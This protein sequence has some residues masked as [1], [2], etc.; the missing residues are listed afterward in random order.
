LDTLTSGRP[1]FRSLMW[2]I[3][4][5]LVIGALAL[6]AG[7]GGDEESAGGGASLTTAVSTGGGDATL[8]V[9]GPEGTK[10]YSLDDLEG[11]PV[12]EGYWG[13]KSSTGRIT[14]PVLAKGVSL[15]DLFKEVGGLPD[16]MAVGITAKDGYEMTMSVTQLKSGDFITYDMVTGDEKKVDGPLTVIVAYEYD[17]KPLDP[18]TDGPLR[19]AMVS[20]EKNQVT[21]GHWSIKWTN[22][23]E[24]KA[25]EQEWTLMLKGKLTE[26]IDKATFESGAAE[27]CHGQSWTDADGNTW[28]G[29]PLYLLVGRVDDDVAHEGPAY[30]REL[31]QA[32]YQVKIT[33]ADG[34]SIEVASTTMYYKKDIIVAYRLNGAALPEEYWPLRLVGEGI[35]VADMVGQITEIE[36]LVPAE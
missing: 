4:L 32:G 26:E 5:L 1:L 19:L 30:N 3:A 9:I 28:T 36:A 11:L 12:T 14:L 35:D 17:G 27:G 10:D 15:E 18:Q 21:D 7:C 16:D 31:A 33:S 6:P 34:A 8:T 24:V 13:M 20:P 23:L 29:I 22:R 2:V 25:I